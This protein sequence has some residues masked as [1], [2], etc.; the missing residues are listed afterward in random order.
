[1]RMS[2]ARRSGVPL[3]ADSR[4]LRSASLRSGWQ[5]KWRRFGRLTKKC[6]D[7]K[8]MASLR[9]EIQKCGWGSAGQDV[10]SHDDAS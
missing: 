2:I 3:Q 6:R 10:A 4:S 9:S 1:M 5:K 7:D 8:E